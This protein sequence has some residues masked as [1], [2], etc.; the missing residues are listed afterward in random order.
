Q[1]LAVQKRGVERTVTL[2]VLGDSTADF[3]AEEDLGFAVRADC[4]AGFRRSPIDYS[5]HREVLAV[6]Q[7]NAM[8]HRMP[9]AVAALGPACLAVLCV[10]DAADARL[11]R[12]RVG[13]LLRRPLLKAAEQKIKQALGAGCGG[14]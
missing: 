14:H 1:L 3:A 13:F 4:P 11:R 8:R 7:P 9:G 2:A 6:A 10:L 12:R 5:L